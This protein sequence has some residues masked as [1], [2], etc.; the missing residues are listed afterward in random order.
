MLKVGLTGGIGSGKSE[1]TR[2][3]AAHGALVV[4]ADTVA[5]EVVAPGSS[6]L[7]AVVAEFGRDVLGADGSLDRGRLAA[8]VFTDDSARRRL[9]AV[10]H[11]LVRAET[12][13]RFAAAPADAVVVND[14][15]LLVEAGLAPAYDVVVVV[16]APAELRLARLAARGLTEPDARARMAAQASDEDRRAVA[17]HVIVN[18]GSL[19]DLDRRVRRLWRALT[20]VP[21]PDSPG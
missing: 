12:A 10:V 14:V 18:D 6:G 5:R 16:E 20:G 17:D 21:A 11:P 13:R 15:P 2:R 8:L 9:N 4:D 3:L 19:A 1:V 7:A